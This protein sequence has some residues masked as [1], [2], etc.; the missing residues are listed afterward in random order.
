MNYLLVRCDETGQPVRNEQQEVAAATLGEF[1]SFEQ[2][3]AQAELFLNKSHLHNGVF[4][5]EADNRMFFLINAQEF[6]AL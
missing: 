5:C 3:K 1:E 4:S 6:C 2:A